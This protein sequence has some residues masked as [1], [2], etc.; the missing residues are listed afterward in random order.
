MAEK[1]LTVSDV[2]KLMDAAKQ[3]V[4]KYIVSDREFY[5]VAKLGVRGAE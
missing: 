1:T 2:F 4:K 5:K 3:A